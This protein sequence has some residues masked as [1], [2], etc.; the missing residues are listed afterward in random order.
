MKFLLFT[1]NI[2]VFGCIV[3]NST[4]I[5]DQLQQLQQAVEQMKRSNEENDEKIASLEQELSSL[6]TL[7]S[8][9]G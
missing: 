8:Q 4:C 2:L 6:R 9:S 5:E 1:L 3:T 7:V